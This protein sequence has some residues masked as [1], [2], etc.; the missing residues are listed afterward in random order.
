MKYK[1]CLTEE[2][3][4]FL[5]KPI[6][7]SLSPTSGS[8]ISNIWTRNYA[9]VNQQNQSV[10]WFY[11][12][13]SWSS[14]AFDPKA[15]HLSSEQWSYKRL[16]H[17]PQKCRLCWPSHSWCCDK[18][19]CSSLVGCH[20]G[21]PRSHCKFCYF[22]IFVIIVSSLHILHYGLSG[23]VYM[24]YP[25]QGSCKVLKTFKKIFKSFIQHKC[26]ATL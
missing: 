8:V 14:E 24:Y 5:V 17:N 2:R 11:I 13:F 18:Y 22:K 12:L 10:T 20:S 9:G 21:I 4:Y 6:K 25:L 7:K 15:S 19:Q 1:I 26:F 23:K 16:W 3:V